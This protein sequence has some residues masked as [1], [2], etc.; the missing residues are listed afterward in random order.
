MARRS[1]YLR[2]SRARETYLCA[3]CGRAI[4]PR[5]AYY[6]DE[7]HPMARRYRGETMR[8]LCYRCVWGEDAAVPGALQGARQL[9]LPF[10]ENAILHPTRVLLVD[11][12]PQL[13]RRLARDQEAMFEIGPEAFE[14]LICDRIGAMGLEARKV[15]STMARDGGVDILFW[16][17]AG[18][19]FPYLGAAQ[20]KYHW[21]PEAKTAV[22]AVREFAGAIG[23]LPVSFGL[24]VTNTSFTADAEWFAR[25]RSAVVRL[26]DMHDL[27][28]W[29]EGNFTDE[30]EWRDLPEEIEVCPGLR[31]RLPLVGE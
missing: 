28:R 21:A 31:I 29:L 2:E 27:R 14:N 15:G 11:V 12:T 8:R 26:R 10:G 24:I 7:P 18:R 9:A 16:P 17:K 1:L 5:E 23:C 3:I 19:G 25:Q 30:E 13:V 4:R 22:G 20:A 6:R